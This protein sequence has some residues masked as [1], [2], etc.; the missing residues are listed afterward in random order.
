MGSKRALLSR[1]CPDEEKRKKSLPNSR[2]AMNM[3]QVALPP[4]GHANPPSV[5]ALQRY[6]LVYNI[7]QEDSTMKDA[8]TKQP[9]YVSTDGTAGPY[10]MVP[11]TQ[12]DELRQI[13][14]R[15]G[16]RYSVDEDAISLDGEPE[17]ATVNLGRGGDAKGVQKILDSVN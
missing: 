2:K 11:V 5:F 9:L 3:E 13:L 17:V 7:D 1:F 6:A 10:I 12:L 8:M 15:Q 4:N 14:D 16:I